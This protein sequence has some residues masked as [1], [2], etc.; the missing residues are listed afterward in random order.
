MLP[1]AVG[2]PLHFPFLIL[3][4]LEDKFDIVVLIA[5]SNVKVEMKDRLPR[6]TSIVGKN[7]ESLQLET[8]DKCLSHNLGGM[9]NVGQILR[10]EVEKILAMDFGNNEGMA[11]VNG[12][13]VEDAHSA[14]VL[15]ENLRR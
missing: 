15:V 1:D 5:W 4:Q 6:D 2:K 13:N 8:G 9:K 7:I 10:G 14:R 3:F 12:I 11:V